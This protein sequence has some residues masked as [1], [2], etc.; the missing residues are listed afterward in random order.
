M[1]P[2]V[3]ASEKGTAQ[4]GVACY[5]GVVGLHLEVEIKSNGLESPAIACDSHVDINFQRRAVS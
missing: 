1:I 5:P 2:Q 3:V 4:T